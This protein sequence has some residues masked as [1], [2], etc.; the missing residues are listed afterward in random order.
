METG[1]CD[2]EAGEEGCVTEYWRLDA[3]T[4]MSNAISTHFSLVKAR[5]MAMPK[6]K[7]LKKCSPLCSQT[8]NIAE[9]AWGLLVYGSE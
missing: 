7:E 3:L 5:H 8:R 1:F 2:A 4:Q 9:Q 6:L